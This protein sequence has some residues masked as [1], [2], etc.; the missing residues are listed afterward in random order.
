MAAPGILCPKCGAVAAGRYCSACGASLSVDAGSI[1]QEVKSRFSTPVLTALA[2]LKAVW[3][4]LARPA[5]FSRAWLRG[6]QAMAEFPFPLAAAWRR[7]GGGRQEIMAPFKALFFALGLIAIAGGLEQ[8]AVKA[9]GQ[10]EFQAQAVRAEREGMQQAARRH[11]GHPVTFV[12]LG[13]LTGIGALDSALK[14]SWTLLSYLAFAIIVAAFMPKAGLVHRRAAE[15]YFAY[16]V[17]AGLTLQATARSIGALLF[18][19]IAGLSIDAALATANVIAL[20]LG[21]LPMVWLGAVLPIRFFPA[22]LDVSRGRIA[23]A[24]LGGLAATGAI[25]AA[26]SQAMLRAGFALM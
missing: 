23:I 5:E 3:L 20:L 13:K 10:A 2:F 14:E 8:L 7:L 16:A 17:A 21:Y 18:V 15:Q 24:V 22:I 4:L 26:L 11:F 12:D 19:P 9:A 6:P 25:N 1:G